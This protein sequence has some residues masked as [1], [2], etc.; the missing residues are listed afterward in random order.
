[1]T[2]FTQTKTEQV[3]SE[4][5]ETLAR[6][7]ELNAQLPEAKRLDKKKRKD[8]GKKRAKY[9]SS[10]PLR[11]R[12]YLGR[13]NKKSLTFEL[14]VEE[15]EA[16]CKGKCCYC[17]SFNKIGVDRKD[18]SL[19]YTIDNVQSCCGTCNWMKQSTRHEDFLKHVDKIY[20]FCLST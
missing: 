18:S 16:I 13:A 8:V 20:R 5:I 3:E 11:Y 19:G 15:F 14:T 6:L 1:M 17:G 9:D 12:Q 4:I 2:I 10:L 7:N